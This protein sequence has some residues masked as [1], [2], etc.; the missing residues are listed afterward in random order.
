M[1]EK[2]IEGIGLESPPAS[3]RLLV[4][5]AEDGEVRLDVRLE[6]ETVWLARQHMAELFQTSVPNICMHLRNIFEE[7]ELD[8]KA[9][10]K[11]FLT[12]RLE[13]SR[14][15]RR[16]LDFNNLDMIIS[17][18]YRVKSSVATRFRQWA[19]SILRHHL[20][21]GYTLDQG[22]ECSGRFWPLARGRGLCA[23]G[24]A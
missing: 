11:K 21:Q 6:G 8:P 2:N 23:G 24:G 18:G 16:S 20:L 22:R 1:A 19:T 13:G 14:K 7:G 4:Y 17:V 9:T 3:G 10:L 12:V 15:V 5:Q